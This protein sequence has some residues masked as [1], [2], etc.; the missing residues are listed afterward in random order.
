MVL[1]DSKGNFVRQSFDYP[2]DTL[3]VGQYLRAGN[4][5]KLVSRASAKE[6]VDGRYSFVMEPKRLS[7]YYQIKSR[8]P[9]PYYTTSGRLNIQDS[10]LEY[11]KFNSAP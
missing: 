5:T 10:S 3:L 11:M 4:A 1:H 7:M 6:N 8:R 9:V 2:T